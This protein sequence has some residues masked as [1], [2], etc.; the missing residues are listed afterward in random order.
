MTAVSYGLCTAPVPLGCDKTA[1]SCGFQQDHNVTIW[2]S[3]NLV[4]WT[5]VGLAFEWTARPPGTLFRPS[6][7]WNPHTR[8]FVMWINL[9]RGNGTHGYPTFT[10]ASA[11]GPFLLQSSMNN[12]TNGSKGA[13]LHRPR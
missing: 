3:P 1:D 7:V 13:S 5:Y 11:S 12:V 9:D 10:S 8:L 4:N 2:R 6:V